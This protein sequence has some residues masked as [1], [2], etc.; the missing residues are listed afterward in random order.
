M[1]DAWIEIIAGSVAGSAAK[2]IEYPFDTTKV[3]LQ[4]QDIRNPVYRGAVDCMWRTIRTEGVMGL[5]RGLSAP[6]VAASAENA[7][8]FSVFNAASRWSW[9]MTCV[10][11]SS[12]KQTLVC[13][14][15]SGFAA[16]F[17][18]T[19]IELVKCKI[20][21]TTLAG[22]KHMTISQHIRAVFRD[23]GLRG[24][25]RAQ[26]ATAIR[27]TGGSAS[28]FGAQ[29]LVTSLL[30]NAQSIPHW[31]AQFLGGAAAGIAYNISFFPADTVKSRMQTETMMGRPKQS[32]MSAFTTIYRE[33]GVVNL[34]RG[35][36]V[37]CARAAPSSAV[38]FYVFGRAKNYLESV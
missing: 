32:F 15:M 8:L 9:L 13:G 17:L 21:V 3:K 25:W 2:L 23:S 1:S 28:W 19:P 14:A 4:A 33:G 6:L 22:K 5:Y 24:F 18:L 36:M 35:A 38:I 11:P 30:E 34:Y 7:T 29:H 27:E 37:T 31:L 26:H 20:Q 16:S 10:G 12:L